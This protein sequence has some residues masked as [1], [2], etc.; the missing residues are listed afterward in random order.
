MKF[1][2]SLSRPLMKF[3]GNPSP[4]FDEVPKEPQP[5]VDEVP[6]EPQPPVDEVPKEPQPPVDEVPREPQ[7]PV[8]EVP[9]EPQPPVDE[10]PR[11]PQPPVDEVPKE[12]VP[13][14]EKDIREPPP[15]EDDIIREPPPPEDGIIREPRPPEV[16]VA[17]GELTPPKE[18][19]RPPGTFPREVGHVER[20]EYTYDPQTGVFDAQLVSSTEPVVTAWDRTVPTADERPVGGWAVTPTPNDVQTEQGESPD[21]EVPEAIKERP[22]ERASPSA[23]PLGTHE[24]GSDTATVYRQPRWRGLSSSTPAAAA[25]TS[26]LG[27][28]GIKSLSL[29]TLVQARLPWG[30]TWPATGSGWAMR[31]SPMRPACSAGT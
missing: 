2:R 21:L 1:P 15:P 14:I 25:V 10:V 4:R 30:Y 26:G 6:R 22:A 5:P 18:A 16:K 11:E 12:P 23:W 17:A 19:P 7:P 13:P 27:S 9:R 8:D 24:T 28:T 20:V 3:P 29:G 31:Y